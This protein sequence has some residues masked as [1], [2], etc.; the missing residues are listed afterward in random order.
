MLEG[1]PDAELVCLV[2]QAVNAREAEAELC[3]RF[4]PRIRL[5]GLRH[6]RS[7]DRAADLVQGVLLALLEA[8]RAGRID[9]PEH[10]ARFV[11]G[12]C[13]NVALRVQKRE[14]RQKPSEPAALDV[15]VFLPSLEQFDVPALLDCMTK[16]DSR[17]R[18]VLL[19]S[20]HAE[21]SADEIAELLE[22][23]AGNVRVVRHRALAQLRR[24]LDGG[25]AAT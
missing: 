15:A 24:C 3:R 7:E 13:R 25:G 9:E 12:T 4:A 16:L 5:Y 6:L 21:N 22:S 18:T 2:A 19:L 23:T 17:S 10:L 1:L 20:F 11:L 14:A 8:A